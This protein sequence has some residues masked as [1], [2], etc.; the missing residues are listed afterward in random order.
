ML[1]RFALPPAEGSIQDLRRRASVRSELTAIVDRD[2]EWFVSYCPELSGAN[3]QG[4]SRE[5]SLESLAQAIQLVLE[6]R[7]EDAVAVR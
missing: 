3:G 7:R 2:G 5:E 4:R 6:D 1:S